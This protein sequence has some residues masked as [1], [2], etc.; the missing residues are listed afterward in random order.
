MS[1]QLRQSSELSRL[2]I[3]LIDDQLDSADRLRLVEL[4]R[5]DPAARTYYL[6]YMLTDAALRLEHIA[7]PLTLEKTSQSN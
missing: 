1:D 3:G 2:L 7:A 5:N 4:L 6:R